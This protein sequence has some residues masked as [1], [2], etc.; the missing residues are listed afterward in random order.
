MQNSLTK[1]DMIY[2]DCGYRA[3]TDQKR[4]LSGKLINLKILNYVKMKQKF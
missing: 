1:S 3:A 2:R 4:R